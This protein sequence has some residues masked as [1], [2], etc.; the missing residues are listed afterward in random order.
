MTLISWRAL[1][2]ALALISHQNITGQELN[3]LQNQSRIG[4]AHYH[5]PHN[6]SR[7]QHYA[8]VNG[9]RSSTN[10]ANYQEG[11]VQL[12][13]TTVDDEEILD[14]LTKSY[15]THLERSSVIYGLTKVANETLVNSECYRQLKHIRRGILRKEP[16]A[17]KVLDASGTKPSGFVFGQNF[18]LGSREA[19]GAVQNPVAITLSKNFDRVMHYGIITEQ[20]PFDVDYRVI[21]LRHSSPWQVEIKLMSEQI[22]HIG[23]CLPC[24]CA[25]KEIEQLTAAYVEGG[26]FA[27]NDIYDMHSEVVY[28]K[29]LKLRESFYERNTFK[30]LWGFGC[31]TLA[32]ML[33]AS[34]LSQGEVATTDSPSQRT[35]KLVSL[36]LSFKSFVKCFDVNANCARIFTI[37]ETSAA[38]IPVIN[39]LRSVCAIW[40]MLFHVMWFM[41]FTVNNKT[42][43][44]S[45]AERVFFQYVSS[46]PLL[47]DVFFT[48]SGFLQTYNFMRNTKQ[49]EIIR[50][51]SLAENTKQFSK[52]LFHRYLRL[53]P[54]YLIIMAVVDL[55]YTYIADISVYHINERFDEI[56]S[57]HWWRNFLFIQNFFDHKDMCLNWTWSLACEMQYFVL[58]TILLFS[59][60]KH[61]KFVKTAATAVFL[62]T[63]IWTYTIGLNSKFQLSFD[64]T[65]ATGTEIYI[66]PFVRIMPYVMGAICAWYFVEKQGQFE[67]SETK[68]RC[69]WNLSILIFFA[70]IYSTIK[71]DMTYLQSISLFVIGRFCF[72]L[73]VCWMIVGSATGR[74]CCWSRV[75]EAKIFQHT[76]RISYA[77]YL[78]NPFVIAFFFSLTNVS[79]T[80]DPF[81]LC[82]LSAGFAV[83]IYIASIVFSL[84]FE[85]P[86]C[87]WSSLL[88][89]RKPRVLQTTPQAPLSVVEPHFKKCD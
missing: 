81:M 62:A 21:Y 36:W 24:A 77:F 16:W 1:L 5:A 73:S 3:N 19:C 41:Y 14:L 11:G 76:N 33:L 13:T 71:R 22:I 83:I 52:L 6:F 87:N 7:T 15:E 75:L 26:L 23:L 88:L 89:K 70:C 38:G 58:A 17:L 27:E 20:A 18:W 51:S 44:I 29:D 10:A 9:N 54:L 30:I 32:L 55:F 53:A 80:A 31:L 50:K 2:M 85:L 42:F 72:S 28:M 46:A 86:Y 56:C 64:S 84:A 34:I 69:L 74:G 66:S 57:Q 78:L 40:I 47:V 63:V 43:L 79:T 61:P 49:I 35:S 12:T 45:Y 59:Y 8:I 48:I 37:T 68:E 25:S 67:L 82:V 4:P 60:A 39:G 65:F